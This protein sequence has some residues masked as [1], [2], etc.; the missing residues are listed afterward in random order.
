MSKNILSKAQMKQDLDYS[1]SN[2]DIMRILGRKI[3]I[4]A[5]PMFSKI[6]DIVKFL[7]MNNNELIIFF[8]EDKVGNSVSGHWESMK[9]D[10]Q[11][12]TVQFFDSYG[13]KPDECRDYLSK[14]KLI[15][16]KEFKP[17]L[18]RLLMN[19]AEQGYKIFYN[20][21]RYQQMKADVST[22]GKWSSNFL[23]NGNLA[24]KNQ[25]KNYVNKLMKKFYTKIP[26]DAIVNW[27]YENYGI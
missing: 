25:Y 20:H 12:K 10:P 26:D 7:E 9:L 5:Y 22:C 23:L 15:Q 11:T 1:L 16:L 17:E 2:D 24:L 18:N 27:C 3:K 8:E 4:I 19:A 14:N 13:L 21:I 6:F